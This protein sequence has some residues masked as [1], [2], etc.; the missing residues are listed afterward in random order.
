MLLAGEPRR[1]EAFLDKL[2]EIHLEALEK[3]LAQA[4][5]FID[6]VL[7]GDD[8]GMQ[9]GPQISPD[10]YRS[11]F[12]PRHKRMWRRARS[13]RPSRSCSTAAA[14]SGSFS[15]TSSTRGSTR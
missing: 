2:V 5:P 9:S 14:A 8:L 3:F 10:M 15:P 6:I 13:L 12:K 7:F 4:G 11:I 1:A